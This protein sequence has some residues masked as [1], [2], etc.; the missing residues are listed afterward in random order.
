MRGMN[1]SGSDVAVQMAVM[2]IF[3]D[4]MIQKASVSEACIRMEKLTLVG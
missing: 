3:V 2:R 4:L 1:A